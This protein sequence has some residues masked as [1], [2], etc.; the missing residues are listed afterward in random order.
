MSMIVTT[1]SEN[2]IWG[3]FDRLASLCVLWPDLDL[4]VDSGCSRKHLVLDCLIR[5]CY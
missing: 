3:Q 5:C 1:F 4:S 2:E